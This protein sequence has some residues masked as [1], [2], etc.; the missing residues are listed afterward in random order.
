MEQTSSSSA[1][2]EDEDHI[3][4][5]VDE[6]YLSALFDSENGIIPISDE[7]YAYELHLQEALFSSVSN[8]HTTTTTTIHHSFALS[9]SKSIAVVPVCLICMDPQQPENLF[10]NDKICSHK[11]CNHC[12]ATYLA[13]K[14]QDNI[15]LVNCPQFGCQGTLDPQTCRPILPQ[16]VYE[17]W[18]NA[19]C[20][21][22]ILGSQKVYCPYKDC[23]AMLVDDGEEEVMASECP[24]CH[25]LFCAKCK[26]SW[27]SGIGCAE[28]QASRND[29]GRE[30][31][32]AIELAKNN[33]WRRCPKCCF[34]VEKI[35][36]C[37]HITCRCKYEFCYG[38]GSK[39]TGATCLC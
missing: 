20:E 26:V 18:E 12:I 15:A 16:P 28:F 33:N 36:G 11:F 14:V 19:L 13:T 37:K 21:S 24:H 17:R 31:L 9:S 1:N 2:T 39:Y 8:H 6:F 23:S 29:R 5:F 27:H 4:L 30:D 34:Y 25:R 3:H 22:M 35:D 10:P 32:M 38:C 7:N